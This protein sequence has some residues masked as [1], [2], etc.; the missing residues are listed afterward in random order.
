MGSLG[1]RSPPDTR[2]WKSSTWRGL[3]KAVKGE[4]ASQGVGEAGRGLK[5]RMGKDSIT[6]RNGMRKVFRKVRGKIPKLQRGP[7]RRVLRRVQKVRKK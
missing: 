7:G 1:E 2:F 5:D 4:E 3:P 6:F